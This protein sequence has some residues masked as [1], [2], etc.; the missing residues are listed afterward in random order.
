MAPSL[1]KTSKEKRFFHCVQLTW[2]GAPRG[3]VAGTAA[4]A[5]A[6]ADEQQLADGALAAPGLCLAD[7]G[8]VAMVEA[9]LELHAVAGR[10]FDDGLRLRRRPAEGLL[11]E[12]VPAALHGGDADGGV[13]VRRRADQHRLGVRGCDGLL[14]ARRGGAAV[15]P[16]QALGGREVDGGPGPP[17]G[18]PAPAPPASR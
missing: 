3:L 17:A 15:L 7:G 1:P 12:D 18:R 16:R 5:V 4:D 9:A 11:A 10:G 6:A 2:R 14:P 8:E 13:Q